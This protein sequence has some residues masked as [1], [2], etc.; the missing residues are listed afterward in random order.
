MRYPWEPERVNLFDTRKK[1]LIAN[2][3]H[4]RDRKVKELAEINEELERLNA[5]MFDPEN[6]IDDT[7]SRSQD[8]S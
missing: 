3:E 5:L 8:P 1:R 6:F 7:S 4:K 2:C